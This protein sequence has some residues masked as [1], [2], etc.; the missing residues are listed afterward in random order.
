MIAILSKLF[1]KNRMDYDNP[2]VRRQYGIL[3]SVFGIILNV[4]LFGLKYFAGLVSGSVAITAD[5]FN[6]LSDAGSSLITVIGFKFAGMKP[7][8]EHPFGHGRFEY[9][10]GL[11]VSM[12]ILMM[13][14]ELGRS[15]IEKIIHPEPVDTSITAFIIL[16]VSI[17]V[18]A[19]MAIY[20]RSIGRKIHSAAM[21]A[22]AVDS[23]SDAVATTV[24]L[25]C[26]GIM[27]GTG[28]NVDGYCGVL[29]ALFIL[30]AGYQAARETMSPLLGVKPEP[31]FVQRIQNIV[32][33]HEEIAGLHDLIVHDYGPGRL[34]I[35][36]HA[37]VPGDKDIYLLH[38]LIDNI[39]AELDQQLGCESVIHMDPIETN[40]ELVMSMRKEVESLVKELNAKL[41]IHDFRMVTG[42]THTNLIF[43]VVLPQEFPMADDQLRRIVQDKITEKY[44]QYFA[45]I[46]VEKEYI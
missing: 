32:M 16:V 28:M 40:N 8:T 13:G 38:D 17:L 19:Y 18:K 2:E 23:F 9:I 30:Y 27:V 43:D 1:I 36:L 11:V 46:K 25:I 45:V 35:S 37:E 41:S 15:S 6:N 12:A 5:A 4:I 14:F 3:G 22:T 26:M 34:M 39:E 7:D 24:V 10:S 21:T 29:V 20:N 31:E 42:N 33:Q 44:P